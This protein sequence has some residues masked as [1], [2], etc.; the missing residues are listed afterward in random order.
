MPD[1]LAP[2]AYQNGRSYVREL[3]GPTFEFTT[4]EFSMV[5]GYTEDLKKIHKTVKIGGWVLARGWAL[6]RDNTV[7]P[8]PIAVA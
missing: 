6:A 7:I 2:E 1:V 8:Y 5:G 4:Q 3:S